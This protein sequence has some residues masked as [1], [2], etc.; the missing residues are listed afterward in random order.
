[1]LAEILE[2]S[3]DSHG[4][5]AHQGRAL[6]HMRRLGDRRSTAELLLACARI[7]AEVPPVVAGRPGTDP[8]AR[9]RDTA[10][11]AAEI[12]NELAAEIGWDHRGENA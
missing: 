6:E 8:G 2:Q 3:G 11:R 7:T 5:L 4:A 10:R 9:A 12:A 1:V